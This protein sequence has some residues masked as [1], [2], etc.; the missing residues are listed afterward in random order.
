MNKSKIKKRL[1][2]PQLKNEQ[3]ADVAS[4][5]PTIAK[6]TV[7]CSQSDNILCREMTDVEIS[8]KNKLLKKRRFSKLLPIVKSVLNL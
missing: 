4:V 7:I 3:K 8:E 5:S 6:P 2:E 1:P